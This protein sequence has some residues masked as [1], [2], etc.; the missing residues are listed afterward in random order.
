MPRRSSDACARLGRD[1]ADVRSSLPRA[2]QA[3]ISICA[4]LPVRQQKHVRAIASRT[5]ADD[6]A[7]IQPPNVTAVKTPSAMHDANCHD[8]PDEAGNEASRRSVSGRRHATPARTDLATPRSRQGACRRSPRPR[9][10]RSTPRSSASSNS[11]VGAR[12]ERS[13]RGA[14]SS[15]EWVDAAI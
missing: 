1:G 6:F 7:T 8:L 10:M 9:L 12:G 11:T 3:R 14:P 5:S 4:R 13:M 2:R 15:R